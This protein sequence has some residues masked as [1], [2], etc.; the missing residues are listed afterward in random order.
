MKPSGVGQIFRERRKSLGLDL[1]ALS[2][3]CGLS[4]AQ[5]CK[6]ELQGKMSVASLFAIAESLGLEIIIKPKEPT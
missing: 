5:I 6:I 2:N 3:R 4:R 1:Q